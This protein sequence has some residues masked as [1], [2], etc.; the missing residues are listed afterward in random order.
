M[1]ERTEVFTTDQMYGIWVTYNAQGSA[2]CPVC[3]VPLDI[4]AEQP[5]DV[6]EDGTALNMHVHCPSCGR[7]GMHTTS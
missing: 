3:S 2:F 6:A 4:E 1:A 7:T 5:I